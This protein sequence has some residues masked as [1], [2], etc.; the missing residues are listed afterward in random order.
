MSDNNE[1]LSVEN[2]SISF[3][4]RNAPVM[5]VDDISFNVRT[6]ETVGLVGES[7]S[8]KTISAR[9]VM[10]LSRRPANAEQGKIWFQGED[11]QVKTEHQMNQIRGVSMSMIFQS[12]RSSLNPLMRVGDQ[13]ARVVRIQQGVGQ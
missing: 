7:G 8:G 9:A 3:P 6:E 2:L 5:V 10:R 12:P 11:I 1:I 13:I 4:G